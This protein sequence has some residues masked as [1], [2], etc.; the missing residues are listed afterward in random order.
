LDSS[1]PLAV[2][3]VLRIKAPALR[4]VVVKAAPEV[5]VAPCTLA[6]RDAGGT[7]LTS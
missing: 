7:I 3:T 6:L 4:A 5:R 2:L 1:P